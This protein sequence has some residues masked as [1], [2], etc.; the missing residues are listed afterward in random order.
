MQIALLYACQTANRI[1]LCQ[2]NPLISCQYSCRRLEKKR[3]LRW[4]KLVELLKASNK[5]D[6]SA[7]EENT[8]QPYMRFTSFE[9]SVNLQG[10]ADNISLY[11]QYKYP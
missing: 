10:K 6:H 2:R 7:L 8:E 3:Y 11:S 4:K 9:G 1:N 5:R